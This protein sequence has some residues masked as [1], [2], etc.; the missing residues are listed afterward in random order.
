MAFNGNEFLHELSRV[1]YVPKKKA[2]KIS[3]PQTFIS[4][5]DYAERTGLSVTKIRRLFK[6]GV[7]FGI[8]DGRFILID[9]RKSDDAL[10]KLTEQNVSVDMLV[11]SLKPQSKRKQNNNHRS[12]IENDI[13]EKKRLLKSEA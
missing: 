6:K 4:T 13:A 12:N 9:W 7:L 3:S 1:G 2:G 5:A 8:R 10:S 11:K